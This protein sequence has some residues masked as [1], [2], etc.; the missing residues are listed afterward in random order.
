MCR[1]WL[2]LRDSRKKSRKPPIPSAS[3]HVNLPD[4]DLTSFAFYNIPDFSI[5]PVVSMTFR[6]R[7]RVFRARPFVFNNIP[8][9]FR[10]KGLPGW[11]SG[12]YNQNVRHLPLLAAFIRTC[13][14]LFISCFRLPADRLPAEPS[15]P[16]QDRDCSLPAIHTG[17]YHI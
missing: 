10:K 1:A 12:V 15:S 11:A 8:D 3:V 17:G 2:G 14:H 9:S 16:H 7:S 6:L 13:S 5:S 4:H